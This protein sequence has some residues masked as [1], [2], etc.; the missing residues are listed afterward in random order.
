MMPRGDAYLASRYT[1]VSAWSSRL[2]AVTSDV[3]AVFDCEL[4]GASVAQFPGARLEVPAGE[5]AAQALDVQRQAG[6]PAG[7]LDDQPVAVGVGA[8]QAVVHVQRGEPQAEAQPAVGGAHQREQRH[9][10]GAAREQQQ[11]S[12]A[13]RGARRSRRRRRRRGAGAGDTRRAGAPRRPQNETTRSLRTVASARSWMVATRACA[14][15]WSS[16]ESSR[17][18]AGAAAAHVD[19]LL[20]EV[21]EHLLE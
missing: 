5:T 17:R 14:T 3:V 10:V 4:P 18:A 12:L 2:C 1:I 8:A 6:L 20:Q 19:A 16:G 21:G 13:A 7:L 9:G 11:R 15:S